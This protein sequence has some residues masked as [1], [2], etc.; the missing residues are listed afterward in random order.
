[1]LLII[2][3]LRKRLLAVADQLDS[4]AVGDPLTVARLQNFLG[5]TL[6]NLGESEKAIDM[7]RQALQTRAK[8]L[9]P[10]HPDTLITMGNLGLAY[11]VAGKLDLA[12]PLFEEALKLTKTRFG[13]YHRD[14]LISTDNLAELYKA[15]GK[16]ELA[17]PLFEE[18]LKVRK[19]KLGP[20]NPLTLLS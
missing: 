1:P 20:Y 11:R 2:T 18:T 7:Y 19:D 15:A 4:E 17:L 6:V 3:H 10:D 14:T 8:L 9:A 12:L 5:N 13:P 16:P